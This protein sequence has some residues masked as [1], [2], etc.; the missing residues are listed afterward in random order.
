MEDEKVY[1]NIDDNDDK[2]KCPDVFIPIFSEE[3]LASINETLR[4][5][6]EEVCGEDVSCLFDIAATEN[7]AIGQSTL[8]ESTQIQNEIAILG[9]KLFHC[10][11]V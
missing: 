2:Y 4:I 8:S 11:I 6:A 10:Y 3:A 7:L 5:Q 1:R 9:K